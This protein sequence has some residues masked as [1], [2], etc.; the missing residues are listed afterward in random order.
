[1]YCQTCERLVQH[2]N[3]I[4]FST[5]RKRQ[6]TLKKQR[7]RLGFTMNFQIFVNFKQNVYLNIFSF[8]L[9][10]NPFPNNYINPSL[11]PLR[12]VRDGPTPQEQQSFLFFCFV[13]YKGF[14]T[15]ARRWITIICCYHFNLMYMSSICGAKYDLTCGRFILNVGVNSPFCT[16]NGSGC[17]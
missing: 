10:S 9:N 5:R 12:F 4:K 7:H 8:I 3:V 11:F 16:E 15:D 17:R 6:W 13:Y 2:I 1:M 14:C